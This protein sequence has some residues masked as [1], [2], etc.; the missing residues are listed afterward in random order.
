M[1]LKTTRNIYATFAETADQRKGRTAV[2]YLGTRFSYQQLKEM[3]ERFAA[4][5]SHAGLR[6]GQKTIIYVP[7]SIQWVV[8][9]LGIQKIGG[10]CVPITPIYTPHDLK[11]IANDSEAEAIVCADTNFGYVTSVLSETLLKKVIVTKMADLLSWWKRGFGWLFDIVPR[12]KIALDG[13]TF[14]FR[15]KFKK[16]RAD[17]PGRNRFFFGRS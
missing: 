4:A 8:A 9:W 1:D 15:K 2:V 5:L 11:Y 6:A 17:H 3:A 12:G 13:N 16:D 14:S 7:N 10:V